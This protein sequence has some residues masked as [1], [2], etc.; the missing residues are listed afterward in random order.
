MR[1][2]FPIPAVPVLFFQPTN[3]I[4]FPFVFAPIPF[5]HLKPTGLSFPPFPCAAFPSLFPIRFVFLPNQSP[6]A[7]VFAPNLRLHP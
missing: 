7:A 6:P 4:L 2:C 3:Y 1:F 5:Q